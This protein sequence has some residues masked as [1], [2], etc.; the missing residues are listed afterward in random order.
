MLRRHLGEKTR[1]GFDKKSRLRRR[2]GKEPEGPSARSGGEHPAVGLCLQDDTQ[3]SEAWADSTLQA[4][5]ASTTTPHLPLGPISL[6][7]P[8]QPSPGLSETHVWP[9]GPRFWGD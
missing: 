9:P 4:L 7:S 3:A 2:P 1:E 6:T 8:A 5:P